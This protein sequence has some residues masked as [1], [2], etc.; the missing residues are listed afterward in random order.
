MF[1]SACL[2]TQAKKRLNRTGARTQPCL[3]PFGDGQRSDCSPLE[4]TCHINMEKADDLNEL[5]RA[6]ITSKGIPQSLS[7][8][9]VKCLGQVDEHGVEVKVLLKAF[10]LNLPHCKYHVHC[11]AT[12]VDSAL[13]STLGFW[14]DDFGKYNETVQDDTSKD[15]PCC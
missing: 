13:E 9:G 14:W 5:W 7:V 12:N 2:R 8:D 4:R 11:A 10:L 15:F 3:T 6:T 1:P